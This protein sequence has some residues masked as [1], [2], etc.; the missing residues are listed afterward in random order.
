MRTSSD[1][2][3]SYLQRTKQLHWFMNLLFIILSTDSSSLRLL[4]V[5]SVYKNLWIQL[6]FVNHLLVAC[7]FLKCH[8]HI[9]F[10]VDLWI[11]LITSPHSFPVHLWI[12]VIVCLLQARIRFICV[13]LPSC[14]WH[15]SEAFIPSW[16]QLKWKWNY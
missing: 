16:F 7:V 6:K 1:M 14:S 8:N 4:S 3:L 11:F 13:L 2:I 10:N 12:S 15:M 5:N 9:K